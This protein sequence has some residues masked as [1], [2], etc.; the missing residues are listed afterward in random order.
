MRADINH[1]GEAPDCANGSNGLQT[2]SYASRDS[3]KADNSGH[4]SGMIPAIICPC[5]QS[6]QRLI[7]TR[8]A[9][10]TGSEAGLRVGARTGS[11][12]FHVR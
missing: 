2:C 12:P 1:S 4:Q 10:T 8:P 9:K 6:V 5:G 11:E 3:A 7:R